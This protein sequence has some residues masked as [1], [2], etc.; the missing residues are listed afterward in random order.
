MNILK[1]QNYKIGFNQYYKLIKRRQIWPV[2]EINLTIK[3][4]EILAIVGASGSGKS[5]LA[6]GIMGILPNNSI[7][8]G[9]IYFKDKPL[10]KNNRKEVIG[11]KIKFIPQSVRNLDPTRKVGKQLEET[12]N[13][14]DKDKKSYVINL[15]K[16]L[17]LD[18]KVYDLYPHQLSG[19]MV[20]RILVATCYGDNTE[21]IIA[22]EPTPGIHPEV[23]EEMMNEFKEFKEKGNSI[24]FITHDMKMAMKIA[25]RVAFFWDGRIIDVNTTEEILNEDLSSSFALK[26]WKAQASNKF[27]EV[28]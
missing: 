12:L 22:D 19:G 15:L 6:H 11:S 1:V 3:E 21:L 28:V 23:L 24:L 7:Q 13:L 27:W 20:R 5:L 10:D 8:K 4:K 18:E 16:S 26:L 2:K 14:D 17:S 9:Q 25:D